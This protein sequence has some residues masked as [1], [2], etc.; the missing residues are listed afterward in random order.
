MENLLIF[1]KSKVYILFIIIRNVNEG[2]GF[3][4]I[5]NKDQVYTFQPQ[6]PRSCW[7][8]NVS[9][10]S[11]FLSYPG[12]EACSFSDILN[13]LKDYIEDEIFKG[14]YLFCFHQTHWYTNQRK[15]RNVGLPY[16]WVSLFRTYSND[17]QK[18]SSLIEGI[19]SSL[20]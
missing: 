13:I 9:T 11:L 4:H 3:T 12:Q 15:F 19:F 16:K 8:W 5:F 7:E 14:S 17:L 6:G 20:L 1:T 18:F 10:E 2:K